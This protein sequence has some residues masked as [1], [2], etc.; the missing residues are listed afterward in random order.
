MIVTLPCSTKG[1]NS[2]SASGASGCNGVKVDR[3]NVRVVLISSAGSP[4]IPSITPLLD[5]IVTIFV[6]VQL[7]QDVVDSEALGQGAS[8]NGTNVVVTKGLTL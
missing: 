3:Y 6:E 5:P 8:T 7:L 2:I 4:S 1:A